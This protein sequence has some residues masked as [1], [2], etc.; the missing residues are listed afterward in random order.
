MKT[1]T[2]CVP[3]PSRI[4]DADKSRPTRLAAAHETSC[5]PLL[6]H[7]V[8]E[9]N[10]SSTAR[11]CAPRFSLGIIRYT[12]AEVSP[13]SR[14]HPMQ[15]AVDGRFGDPEPLCQF[16]AGPLVPEIESD[17]LLLSIAQMRR[18]SGE[19]LTLLLQRTT[20][21]YRRG[22]VHFEHRRQA[23]CFLRRTTEHI[24]RDSEHIGPKARPLLEAFVLLHADEERVLQQILRAIASAS[25]KETIQTMPIP[26]EKDFP[27]SSMPGTPRNQEVL[28]VS[29]QQVSSLLRD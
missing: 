1:L 10:G 28:I 8:I 26:S 16:V 17:Q 29:R 23:P 25:T 14:Q 5:G 6:R 11:C 4:T 20:H 19:E 24:L 21:S 15:A 7:G 12:T 9:T 18:D 27:R 2:S 3:S 13:H 22:V